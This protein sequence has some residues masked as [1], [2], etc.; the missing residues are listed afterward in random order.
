VIDETEDNT[1]KIDVK[2]IE[3]LISQKP[4][5]LNENIQDKLSQ[6][7]ELDSILKERLSANFRKSNKESRSKAKEA[8]KDFS[9]SNLSSKEKS[10]FHFLPK[11]KNLQEFQDQFLSE[12]L[13]AQKESKLK[14][15]L[16]LTENELESLGIIKSENKFIIT[17]DGSNC[18]KI[19][20]RMHE[21]QEGS[22]YYVKDHPPKLSK[23][24]Q[25]IDNFVDT[26]SSKTKEK[27]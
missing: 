5:S 11:D 16:R 24:Y 8:V 23:Q 1:E 3:D 4:K 17:D 9:L 18:S 2:I 15:K 22:D 13:N 12:Q 14:I 26:L 25:N 21:F 6:H 20:K 7:D 27:S 19:E 10:K